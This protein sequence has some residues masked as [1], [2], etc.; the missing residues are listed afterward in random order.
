M[1]ELLSCRSRD[2]VNGRSVSGFLVNLRNGTSIERY[3]PRGTAEEL[4]KS[5][6]VQDVAKAMPD[7]ENGTLYTSSSRCLA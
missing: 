6:Y 7:E 2:L 5:Q 4:G 3:V 1:S